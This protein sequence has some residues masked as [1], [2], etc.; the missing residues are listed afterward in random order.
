MENECSKRGENHWDAQYFLVENI[1]EM[2]ERFA[3]FYVER[4]VSILL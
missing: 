4:G 1:L 2:C 3:L